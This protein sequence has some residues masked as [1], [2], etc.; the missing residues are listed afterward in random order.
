MCASVEM[1]LYFQYQKPTMKMHMSCASRLHFIKPRQ[2]RKLRRER[3]MRCSSMK[4]VIFHAF[5][6]FYIISQLRVTET[7]GSQNDV[8]V[9]KS[10]EKL[11]MFLCAGVFSSL[12]SKTRFIIGMTLSSRLENGRQ[13]CHV[14]ETSKMRMY[15]LALGMVVV[16]ALGTR[17]D[18]DDRHH[19]R[20]MRS[21]GDPASV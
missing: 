14:C 4:P 5:S 9:P 15:G 13:T 2:R 17:A 1:A 3:R 18:D 11:F 7:I 20:E 12:S 10:N 16:F 19:G 21:H 6:T 8:L